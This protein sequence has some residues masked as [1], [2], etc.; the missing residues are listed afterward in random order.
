MLL[1]WDIHMRYVASD[2]KFVAYYH[3]SFTYNHELLTIT[4]IFLMIS[5]ISFVI[6]IYLNIYSSNTLN[7]LLLIQTM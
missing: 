3:V 5:R 1:R 2:Y 7:D 4:K 6:S